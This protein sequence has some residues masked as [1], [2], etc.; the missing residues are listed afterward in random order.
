MEK[1]VLGLSGGVDSAVAASLLKEHGFAV[2][3]LYLD[4][5]LGGAGAADAAAVAQRQSIPFE[6]A[7]I[8]SDLEELVCAPFAAA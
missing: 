3:G 4:I 1:I 6:V 5:G 8:R 7:D 2:T